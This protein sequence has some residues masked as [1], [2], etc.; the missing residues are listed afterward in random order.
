VVILARGTA[1]GHL[2]VQSIKVIKYV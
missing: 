1:T 2:V